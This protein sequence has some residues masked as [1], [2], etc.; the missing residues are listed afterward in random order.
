MGSWDGDTLPENRYILPFCIFGYFYSKF[1][2]EPDDILVFFRP[3][4]VLS[5][6]DRTYFADDY[7]YENHKFSKTCVLLLHKAFNLKSLKCLNLL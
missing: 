6:G 2:L 3:A 1:W 4:K 5:P 7:E